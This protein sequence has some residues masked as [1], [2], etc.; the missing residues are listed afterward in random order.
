MAMSNQ[1]N[2]SEETLAGI[3]S[4][5]TTYRALHMTD[6]RFGFGNTP[7]FPWYLKFI[8]ELIEHAINLRDLALNSYMTD[9]PTSKKV[10]SQKSNLCWPKY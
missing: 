10:Q 6:I 4:G 2:V 7:S 1:Y 5:V 3:C 9:S 8:P